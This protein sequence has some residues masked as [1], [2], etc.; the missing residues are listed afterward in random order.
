[1]YCNRCGKE[2]AAGQQFCSGCGAQVASAG[3]LTAGGRVQRHIQL[4]SILWF[5]YSFFS[6]AAGVVLWVIAR[7]MLSHAG[8]SGEF[9]DVPSFVPSLLTVIGVLI[10]AKALAGFAA[11]W[12]LLQRAS[13]ARPLTLVLGFL[14][15]LNA[16][17]GTALGIYTLWVLLPGSAGEEYGVLAAP[18]KE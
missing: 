8:R 11:G 14:S 17:F 2:M 6:L 3:V 12:G 16:P 13:W 9:E 4:L 7:V 5:V 18:S 10:L 15:L 1:M